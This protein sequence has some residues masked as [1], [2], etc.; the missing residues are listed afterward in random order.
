LDILINKTKEEVLDLVEDLESAAKLLGTVRDTVEGRQLLARDLTQENL[1]QLLG[2]IGLVHECRS[3]I[4]RTEG[5]LLYAL[6]TEVLQ[7]GL[8]G[9]SI[10]QKEASGKLLSLVKESPESV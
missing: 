4:Q 5:Q 7:D 2:I 10:S 3:Q 1:Q 8:K 9:L 6:T